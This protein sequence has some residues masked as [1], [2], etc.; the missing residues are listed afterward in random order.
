MSTITSSPANLQEVLQDNKIT[1]PGQTAK[2]PSAWKPYERVAFRIAFIFFIGMSIPMGAE[3]YKNLFTIN[4]FHVHYRDLY[5]I[6]RFQ[7]SLVRFS[8]P[9]LNLLGWADWVAVLAI[10]TVGGLIWTLFDSKNKEY[11]TLYYWLRVVVRYRAGIGIIG[12]GFTK[13]FPVQMPYP[14]LGVLNANFGDLTAQKIYWL[15]VGI[16]PWYQVFAGIVEVA[17]GA[18]L[19]FRKTTA[20]GAIMLFAALGDITY[21]NLAYDGGV[22]VYAS[23]FVLFAGFLLWLDAVP[24]YNL[25]VRERFTVP[26]VLTPQFT[27]KW[28]RVTRIILKTLTILIFG[29]LLFYVQYVNWRYDPYKQPAMKGVKQLRGNYTVS[30]FKLNGEDVPYSPLD[31]VR[32]QNV[33]FEKWS[34]LTFNVHKPLK[35]DLSNGGGSPMRDINRSFEMTGVAGGHRVF[36]Y[37][38]DTLNKVLYL[39]D[40]LA[41]SGN[42]RG[43]GAG[44]KKAEAPKQQKSFIPEDA[45]ANIRDEVHGI[46][47]KAWSTRR[48]RGV[49]EESKDTRKRA[50]MVLHYADSADGAHVILT[51][52]DDHKNDIY[53]VL[54]RINRPY[55][56][57]DSKLVAGE[58]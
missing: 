56:L 46:D 4:W 18:M 34:S 2:Q 27:Q 35:L 1:S 10:A 31:S 50:R 42:R 44:R 51:G 20:F 54:D 23:Y 41:A 14:S 12:F 53:I 6:A 7:P 40:K 43:R 8:N 11:R 5:D 13:L 48:E 57:K 17:A 19:F 47:P 52:K 55:A 39:Q 30:E 38:A 58:Y 33:T 21:V 26:A 22:H 9:A 49:P 28:L 37:D 15:S 25:V 45:K 3:W 16:V 32:W 36:Y 24:V 29:V